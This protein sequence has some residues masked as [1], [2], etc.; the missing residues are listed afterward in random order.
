MLRNLK[1]KFLS[2]VLP[3]IGA[4]GLLPDEAPEL[5]KWLFTKEI[6]HENW[7]GPELLNSI[8]EVIPHVYTFP[9]F[10]DEYCAWLIAYAEQEDKWS[11]DRS[12][13]YT[14]WEV[15]LYDLNPAI[16]AYHRNTIIMQGLC[17]IFAG[18]IQW[19]P[20]NV[21]KCFLI[22]YEATGECQEMDLHHDHDSLISLSINL[23]DGYEGGGLSF[24]RHPEQL[25]TMPKG[26]ACLFAGN[27]MMS[28]MAHPVTKGTRYVLVYWTN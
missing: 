11:F 12:D 20:D 21:D 28:H 27:P 15:S 18:L 24:I 16:D 19:E 3:K 9:M 17:Q 10:S 5:W 4:R 6:L 22:K 13:D 1:S 26:H 23:N 7:G 14:G 25:V 2:W 8:V